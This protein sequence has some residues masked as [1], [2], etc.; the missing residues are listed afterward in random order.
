VNP[1]VLS[2][3]S[4]GLTVTIAGESITTPTTPTGPTTA[5]T[6]TAS[7]Y[8]TAGAVSSLGH[9]VQYMLFWGDGSNSPWLAVGTT[10]ASHSWPGPGT[11][12]VTAQARCSI[13]TQVLSAISAGRSVVVTAGE[14]IST[15]AAPSGPT[16]VTV[17]TSYTYSTGG[18]SVS[19]GNAVSY[20]F[21]WGDGQTSG[22]LAA[23]TTS[24][25]HSW[26]A[27]GSYNVTTLA[28]DATALLIQSSASSGLTVTVSMLS[29]TFA[30]TVGSMQSARSGQTATRLASGQILVAGGKNSSGVLGSSELYKSVES[31]LHCF[32]DNGHAALDAV[33]HPL[34]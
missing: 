25:S 30:G 6:G 23:G 11:Y 5:V 19:S 9:P 16:A 17:G 13:D 1:S 32:G 12:T 29:V 4:P 3:V 2:S 8:S 21:N 18:A 15:P 27:S 24:S 20:L 22:W 34:E 28:A 7:S 14:T 33:R 10:S 31:D 26:T